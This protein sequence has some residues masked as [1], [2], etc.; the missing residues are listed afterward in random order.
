MS[1][2]NQ[3][4]IYLLLT[5]ASV[6]FTGPLHRFL[7]YADN[8]FTRINSSLNYYFTSP[9]L[10]KF[11]TLIVLPLGLACLPGGLYWLIKR[12]KMPYFLELTWVLWVIFLANNLISH[13]L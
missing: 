11:I 6:Y 9:E 10:A 1:L 4:L 3:S 12:K 8:V 2:F 13:Y 5:A 7:V